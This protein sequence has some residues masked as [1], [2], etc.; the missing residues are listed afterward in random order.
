MRRSGSVTVLCPWVRSGIRRRTVSPPVG[1]LKVAPY[2]SYL[3]SAVTPSVPL[4]DP[5]VT[6]L[7][8]YDYSANQRNI[9]GS[10]SR[11]TSV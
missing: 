4:D 8:N 7:I 9:A 10:N 1:P 3:P 5:P 2:T 6:R 11:T